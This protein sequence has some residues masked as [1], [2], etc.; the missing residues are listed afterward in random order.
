MQETVWAQGLS[1]RGQPGTEP[2]R[3]KELERRADTRMMAQDGKR[4]LGSDRRFQ[5]LRGV[6]GGGICA[7]PT[8]CTCEPASGLWGGA[9]YPRQGKWVKTG[10]WGHGVLMGLA[11]AWCLAG[12]VEACLHRSRSPCPSTVNRRPPVAPTAASATSRMGVLH[13]VPPWSA[14]I[15][16]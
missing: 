4:C 5:I 11:N 8:V 15:P 1:C 2:W 12:G 10:V 9:A 14:A 16:S 7:G 6:G 3:E 13:L